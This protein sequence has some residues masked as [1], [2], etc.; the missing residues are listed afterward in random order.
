MFIQSAELVK[1]KQ[2][3]LNENNV[4]EQEIGSVTYRLAN[5]NLA[6]RGI[7]HNLGDDAD[8]SF[9]HGLHKEL[10]FNYI[11]VNPPFNLKG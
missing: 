1:A 8:S 2:G 3:N 9:T 7:S 11:M 5:M 10:Y 4:C 6:L